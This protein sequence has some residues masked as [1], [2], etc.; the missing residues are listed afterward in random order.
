MMEDMYDRIKK[1]FSGIC[2]WHVKNLSILRTGLGRSW[3]SYETCAEGA[4]DW[5]KAD[6][7]RHRMFTVMARDTTAHGGDQGG[8]WK[9]YDI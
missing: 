4:M 3:C 6:L 7:N 2:H 5:C 1:S 9:A 8:W